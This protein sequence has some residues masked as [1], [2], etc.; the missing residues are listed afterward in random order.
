MAV[1]IG[2]RIGIDGE[3]DFHQSLKSIDAT[4]KTLGSEL[5]AVTA[6]FQDNADSMEALTAKADVLTRSIAENESRLQLMSEAYQRQAARV[7][8]LADALQKAKQEYGENSEEVT[9]A[10]NAYDSAYNSLQYLGDQVNRT[11]TNLGNLRSQLSRVESA[12]EQSDESTEDLSDSMDDAGDASEGLGEQFSALTVAAGNLI[13]D[14]IETLLDAVKNLASTVWNMDEATEEYR[15]AQG[16]LNTAF[17]TAGYSSDAASQAYRDFYGILGDT[18][19]ATEASQLLAQL[20]D[21][22]KDLSEWTRIAAGVSGKFGDSIPIESLIEAANETARTGTVVGT[23]ADAL[24]WA[25]SV[26]EDDF[27]TMLESCSTE[28]ERNQLI[29]ETLAT[30]Y[31]DAADAFYRNNE[32][33][34]AS[35][36]AQT[37]LNDATAQ[38]GTTI[39]GVKAEL[40]AEYLPTLTSLIGTLNGFLSGN[41][42]FGEAMSQLGQTA[43]QFLQQVGQSVTELLPS[44]TDIFATIGAQAPQIIATFAQGLMAGIPQLSNTAISLIQSFAAYIEANLPQFLQT[45]LTFLS[46]F[47]GMIRENAG[48]LVDAAL[49]LISSLAQGIAEGI[50]TLVENIPTIVSNIAGVINDNAPKML[51][52]ALNLIITLGKGLV[53]AIP[54]LV[55]NIPEILGAMWDAF[56]A[57]N[58]VNLGSSLV[59]SISNGLKNAG[60]LLKT[61]AQNLGNTIKTEISALPGKMLQAGKDIVQGLINGIKSM[62][63]WLKNQITSFCTGVLDGFLDFFGIH[64]PSTVMRDEVGV[65]LGRGVAE[66]LDDSITYVTQAADRIGEAVEAKIL[67]TQKALER[68][69]TDLVKETLNTQ[70]EALE[71]FRDEYTDALDDLRS[72][73]QSMTDLLAGYGDLFTWTETEAGDIF[74]LGSLQSQIDAIRDY[75]SA[76]EALKNRGTSESLLNE[77]VGLSVDDATAYTKK[78]LSMT[79]EEYSSYI[80]L[81]EEKQALAADIAKQFYSSELASIEAEFVDKIPESLSSLKDELMSVGANCALGLAEGFQSESNAIQDA[82]VST[83]QDALAAA[84]QAMGVH[85]PSTVWAGFGRNLALGLDEGFLGAMGDVASRMQ[86]AIPMPTMDAINDAIANGVNGMAAIAPQDTYPKEI[87]LILENGQQIA[88]WLLPY[89]RAA[90]RSNPEVAKA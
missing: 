67:E 80:A 38:L 76:L 79:D 32:V 31:G 8:D 88:R 27:N 37:D 35:R 56:T 1:D 48:M 13:S 82:F 41:L 52:A 81:W 65:Q 63:T 55:A 36:D 62:G 39:A 40:T 42:N 89:S 83:T 20:A 84:E 11:R 6:E 78:L 44:L 25:G 54:T 87:V 16:R 60:S 58:W 72:R 74:D 24:N 10:Q 29:M 66:G 71:T 17:E 57:F 47:T 68:E 3:K 33:L 75:G 19:A 77:I 2:P 53:D 73:Q 18:D 46:D 7:N 26:G 14:G 49:D 59:K 12:M 30:T 34:V 45:A 43:G 21:D 5:K 70:L 51:E 90:A 9:Q 69:Q 28:A 23:L 50:P 85:S 64:S 61:E 4:L 15:Q 22:E 86:R